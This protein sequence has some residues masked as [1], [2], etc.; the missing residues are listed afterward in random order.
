M[1]NQLETYPSVA[2]E[3]LENAERFKDFL[4]SETIEPV[5][6]TITIIPNIVKDIIDV[7]HEN[8]RDEIKNTQFKQKA[9][10]AQHYL[11]LQDK[12]AQRRYNI[13]LEKIHLQTGISIAEINQKREVKL[14]AIKA[15]KRTELQKIQSN[16][17]IQLAKIQ[18][19]Y[20]LARQEQKNEIKKFEKALQTSNKQYKKKMK[21]EKKILSELNIII[22]AITNKMMNGT[23]NDNDYKY[24]ITLTTLQ[25]QLLDKTYDISEGFLNIFSGGK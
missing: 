16:E 1:S 3:I 12:N 23:I 24:L 10:L 25:I 17:H 9:K 19:E 21:N 18:S 11:E 2:N 20:E 15:Q 22:N 8:K 14:A 5:N 7:V 13:E 4:S 6:K